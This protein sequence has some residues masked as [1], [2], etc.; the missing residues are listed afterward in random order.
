M[1]RI[2]TFLLAALIVLPAAPTM[3]QNCRAIGSSY[4]CS[5]GRSG[6]RTP[7]TPSLNNQT[8]KSPLGN[9]RYTNPQKRAK[10]PDN[11]LYPTNQNSTRRLGDTI[12]NRDGSK[13][14]TVGNSLTCQ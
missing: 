1:V 13:C 10:S 11:A 5:D 6:Q 2:P 12:Y 9:Q 3:A 8:R 7:T 4:F 14:R